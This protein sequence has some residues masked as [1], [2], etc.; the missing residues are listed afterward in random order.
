MNIEKFHPIPDR[1]AT[2][3]AV[4]AA[5]GN[6]TEK[7]GHGR[8]YQDDVR[9]VSMSRTVTEMLGGFPT[10]DDTI[11]P[12]IYNDVKIDFNAQKWPVRDEKGLRFDVVEYSLMTTVNQDINQDEVP[13]GIRQEVLEDS[14]EDDWANGVTSED[15][16]F[17]DLS[18]QQTSIYTIY[19]TGE[20][21]DYQ[22][23][24]SYLADGYEWYEQSYASDDAVLMK[25]PVHLADGS[26]IDYRPSF[27]SLL[28]EGSM[29][30]DSQ[31]IDQEWQ[32]FVAQQA[33]GEMTEF[34][35]QTPQ[36]RS[37][38]VLAGVAL[39]TSGIYSWRSLTAGA[40]RSVH[41][42]KGHQ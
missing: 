26:A 24:Y 12:P 39:L 42:A 33:F 13:E 5:L 14:D 29:V 17:Y 16:S 18:R 41:R 35:G 28:T 10:D 34:A 37:R 19:E 9:R 21:K 1:L 20:C 3:Q 4:A 25:A 15:L 7:L 11:A 23:R 36:E 30:S 31:R 8:W 32:D 38:R 6:L 22:I 2:E 40:T 27:L